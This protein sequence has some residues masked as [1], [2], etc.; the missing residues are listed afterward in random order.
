MI[1]EM[2]LHLVN[3]YSGAGQVGGYRSG[4]EAAIAR[5]IR[6]A[7]YTILP[8][9]AICLSGC[10]NTEITA[11]QEELA[12][13]NYAAAHEKFVAASHSPKLRAGDW[14]ELAD[15]LCLTEAKIGPPQ[16]SL[17]EQRRICADAAARAGSSSGPMLA[18]ID[19]A[20]RDATKA[21]VYGALKSNDI[22]GAQ[23][24]VVRYQSFP[25]ADRQAVAQ[26]SKQIW[27]T[28]EQQEGRSKYRDR[29]LM[30]AITAV[31]QRY[32]G[33][34][35]MNDTAFKRWVMNN[36]TVSRTHL[37]D[38]IDL[39]EGAID[40]R[41]ASGSLPDI[42]LNLDRFARIN[43]AMVARCRCDGRTNIAVEGSGL[44]AYLLRL[45]PETR[46]SEVLVMP[47]PR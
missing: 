7:A 19:S 28:L 35:A 42:A 34:R 16:Y 5:L 20:E 10:A 8:L 6:A 12:K 30:P 27:S 26:W 9:L 47:Q 32:A 14:R 43:D 33:M 21:E 15:G 22:A 31:S 24:A 18:R 25:G 3:S 40:L 38:R 29:H 17:A 11:A 4:T 45:D 44:P 46:H 39:R 13:G 41:V 36:A 2:T 23:A 37:V 1:R